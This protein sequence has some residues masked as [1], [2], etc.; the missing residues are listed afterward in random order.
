MTITY[1]IRK[2]NNNR[3]WEP[4]LQNCFK[5]LVNV[6]TNQRETFIQPRA[7]LFQFLNSLPLPGWSRRSLA[8]ELNGSTGCFFQRICM[9]NVT[10][11]ERVLL[12]SNVFHA[13]LL[14][15]SKLQ[16]TV[17]FYFE[18]PWGWNF[19]INFMVFFKGTVLILA[20]FWE[21]QKHI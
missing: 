11:E 7:S 13:K 18:T 6:L 12:S 5:T 14:N 21:A 1:S 2:N 16:T 9:E 4:Y 20:W 17:K 15:F 3:K 10:G 19:I 8:T